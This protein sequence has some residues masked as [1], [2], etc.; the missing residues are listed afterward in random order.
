M[1]EVLGHLSTDLPC[2]SRAP[3]RL[4]GRATRA[5]AAWPLSDWRRSPQGWPSGEAAA[6]QD[7]GDAGAALASRALELEAEL[8]ALDRNMMQV[9]R[10]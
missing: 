9:G 7:T 8:A 1:F 10:T 6:L 5:S 4:C 3:H 2:L